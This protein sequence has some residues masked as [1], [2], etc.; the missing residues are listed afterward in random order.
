MQSSTWMGIL[1]SAAMAA[2]A[3]APSDG[4]GADL[5]DGGAAVGPNDGATATTDGAAVTTA[6][7]PHFTTPMFFN[8]DVSTTA[9]AANSDSIIAAHF[10]ITGKHCQQVDQA[11]GLLAEP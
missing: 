3:G 6:T 9:K 2:C 1:L 8:R 11:F 5:T 4:A 7:G 10:A